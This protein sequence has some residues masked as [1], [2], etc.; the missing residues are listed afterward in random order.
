MNYKENATFSLVDF[1]RACKLIIDDLEKEEVISKLQEIVFK[2]DRTLDIKALVELLD[3]RFECYKDH[4]NA[5]DIALIEKAISL[6]RDYSDYESVF[7][8]MLCNRMTDSTDLEQLPLVDSLVWYFYSIAIKKCLMMPQIQY[9]VDEYFA[10]VYSMY[11]DTL[12]PKQIDSHK[13][14]IEGFNYDASEFSRRVHSQLRIFLHPLRP[15]TKKRVK[16][17]NIKRVL[18]KARK[19]SIAYKI[20]HRSQNDIVFGSKAYD[21]FGQFAEVITKK[22]LS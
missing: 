16:K 17:K 19:I 20:L 21:V 5:N 6:I 8:D 14:C 4:V 13:K 7:L 15:C 18:H 2:S 10:H 22:Y 1:Q 3:Q 9:D 11:G 12:T